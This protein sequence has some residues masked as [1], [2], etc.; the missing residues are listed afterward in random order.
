VALGEGRALADILAERQAVTE[1]VATSAAAV[2]LARRLDVDM[3]VVTAVDGILHS[4]A[5]I[6]AT[7]RALLTRP[8]KAE[9]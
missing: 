1:G 2:R 5:D 3:P 9:A 6:G 4:Y 7:I 8:L